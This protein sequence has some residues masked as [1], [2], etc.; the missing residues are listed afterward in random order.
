MG[1]CW[2]AA[3][4][5][6]IGL[7]SRCPS[8]RSMLVAT[9]LLAAST[10]M[11][12]VGYAAQPV[13]GTTPNQTRYSEPIVHGSWYSQQDVGNL[14]SWESRPMRRPWC[15][16]TSHVHVGKFYT[17]TEGEVLYEPD[18]C[19]LVRLT[20][21]DARTC[22]AN[23]TLLF[24]GDSITR[25]QYL[26]F[27]HFLAKSVYPQRWGDE[28]HPNMCMEK[29]FESWADFFANTS[30][31]LTNEAPM[32]ATEEACNCFRSEK[33]MDNGTYEH[34]HFRLSAHTSGGGGGQQDTI[35]VI[36]NS[37]YMWP[38]IS[39][40]LHNALHHGLTTR[41]VDIAV[42]NIG[43]WYRTEYPKYI[44]RIAAQFEATLSLP[45]ALNLTTKMVW[46]SMSDGAGYSHK[47]IA[48]SHIMT[49]MARFYGWNVLEVYSLTT[50]ARHQGV[51]MR[52]DS[53]HFLP[54]MYDQWNDLLLH[55]L[56]AQSQ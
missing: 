47:A 22:L 41:H 13:D 39:T 45:L 31:A 40:S 6:E 11:L 24:V 23:K 15:T 8:N 53:L 14:A 12:V 33:S 44:G 36:Y 49:N 38:S 54:A 19:R 56:C 27:V 1:D 9:I 29:Q 17:T 42:V 50:R 5:I 3:S 21:A 26:S 28:P 43:A 20:A 25:Y 10:S 37:T 34:R 30:H 52:W 51:P 46:R 4:W 48:L 2:G 18:E 7:P 35:N 55:H 16:N 32:L